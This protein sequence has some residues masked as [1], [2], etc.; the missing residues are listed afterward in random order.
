MLIVIKSKKERKSF[1]T[2]YRSCYQIE[3]TVSKTRLRTPLQ[4]THFICVNAIHV[5]ICNMIFF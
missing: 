3:R 4:T 2:V 1:D 5:R